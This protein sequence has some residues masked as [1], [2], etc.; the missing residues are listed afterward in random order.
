LAEGITNGGNVALG[1]SIVEDIL[2]RPSPLGSIVDLVPHAAHAWSIEYPG[3]S[4][5]PRFEGEPERLRIC[6][7]TEDIVGPVRNGGI[8]TTY[9]ALAE[10]L[11]K[12]GHDVTVLYLQGEFVENGTLEHWIEHYAAKDVRFVPVPNYARMDR[13]RVGGDRWLQAPYNMLKFLLEH[14]MDVVH[15]SEWRG[16][17]YLSLLAKRQ[18]LAFQDTL[19]VVKTS[20]PWLWNRL[21]GS[22][23]LDR[24]DDLAKM[25]A[26]R[27]SVELAD[28]VIGG[29]LH[30]L[31][32]MH[33]QGYAVPQA[34]TFVQPNVATYERLSG[35]V[36]RR[37]GKVGS[38]LPVD[39]IVFFGRLESRKGLVVFIQ[40]IKR[41]LRQGKPLPKKIS[42]MGKPGERLH[43]R[44]NQDIVEYIQSETAAWPTKVE[45]L[46]EFQQYEALEY[47]LDGNRLAVMPSLIENS[48]LAVYE[49]A[50]CGVPFVASNSGGTPELVA[51]DDWP[52]VLCDPHPI[53]L[54]EKICEAMERGGYVAAP[55]FDNDLNLEQWRRFHLD[56]GRGLLEHLLPRIPRGLTP[57]SKVSVCVYHADTE[58]KL[59]ATL[60]SIKA[61]EQEADEIW[62]AVDT[63]DEGALARARKIAGEA[64][65]TAN[66]VP[67]FDFD[68][69]QAFNHLAERSEAEF[70]FFL[71]AGA[72]IDPAALRT[73]TDIA[74]SS[75]AD[76]VNYFFRVTHDAKTGIRDYLNVNILG[77]VAQT[78]FRTDITAMPFLVRRRV[79]AELG[80]FTSD[81]RALSHDHE[82]VAKAQL[83][84]IRCE[85]ALLELGTV[86]AWD[87]EWLEAKCYDQAVSQFRTIRPE[88]AATP[89]ALRELLLMAKGLQRSSWRR[90]RPA[91]AKATELGPVGGLLKGPQKRNKTLPPSEAAA[92]RR[93]RAGVARTGN[94]LDIVPAAAVW[95][96][97]RPA[98][99][100]AEARSRV[101]DPRPAAPKAGPRIA[102][103]HWLSTVEGQRFTGR[104]FGVHRGI[105]YGVVRNEDK[106]KEPVDVEVVVDGT[107]SRIVQAN[108]PPHTILPASG[109]HK[110]HGFSFPVWNWLGSRWRRKA[111][112][113]VLRV[114]G[115]DVEIGELSVMPRATQLAE[116]GLE[117]HCDIVDTAVR[118][119]VWAPDH[120]DH[121]VDVSVFIDGRF[122]ARTTAGVI[123]EDLRAANIGTGAYGFS[124]W[125]PAQ[126]RSGAPHDLEVMATETGVLLRRGRVKLGGGTATFVP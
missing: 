99:S 88:L 124:I 52:H 25:H 93:A 82:F 46:S 120:P 94:G 80:G 79:F 10:V 49:A 7:A 126:L 77:S 40:A 3:L 68:A 22:H 92:A 101:S 112:D 24:P 113:I 87:E 42:F 23:L 123:R 5:L 86:P 74:S 95:A 106:L 43:A 9:A 41:L 64:G 8:G 66:V 108:A 65:V 54:A 37:A 15:V 102:R 75:G 57:S 11:G 39:E 60:A 33:S 85:T 110:N 30:L 103:L 96:M 6:I 62:I 116:A 19:F 16:S 28:M 78:F 115:T 53:P 117:G 21:Y 109:D 122:L 29:S 111:R 17:G 27:R 51:T 90:G 31:R 61:Q 4:A 48:S 12:L 97:D 125:V 35:L 104:L 59:A 118:G 13:F 83:S 114:R 119:W 18:G 63:D 36:N 14:P 1:S 34:R 58:K 26:E 71:W 56:L 121:Q 38:R 20:S 84:G 45:I 73:L 91:V 47:L 2:C 89:L 44:M 70:V 107:V 98:A 32:W 81:Y 67:A 55:S 76:V 50:I 69:G 100:A 72:T 105:V